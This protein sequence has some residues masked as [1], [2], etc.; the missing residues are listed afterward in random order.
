L[1]LIDVGGDTVS[2]QERR[3]KNEDATTKRIV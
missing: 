3:G 2:P 1:L